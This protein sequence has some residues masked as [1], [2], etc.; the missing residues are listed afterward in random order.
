M[1]GLTKLYSRVFLEKLL[2]A[3]LVKKLIASCESEMFTL[4]NQ[5]RTADTF[6][7]LPITLRRSLVILNSDF[8]ES[9]KS[10]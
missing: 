5:G 10:S 4:C 3:Q 9:L 7:D 6:S 8:S 2:L 1:S